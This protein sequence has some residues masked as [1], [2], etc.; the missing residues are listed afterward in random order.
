MAESHRG[1][2]AIASVPD[3][4]QDRLRETMVFGL[5]NADADK[6]TFYFERQVSWTDHDS[7]D[8]PWDWTSAPAS[9][10]TVAPTQPICAVEFFAPL[11]RS[12][13]QYSEVG[14]F[15]PSTVVITFV[16][17]DDFNEAYGSSYVTVGPRATKWYFRYWKPEVSLGNIP[18]LQAHFQAE[19]TT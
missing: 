13:A 15:F 5:P 7:E 18:V 10:T 11:G 17:E 3:F 14:D 1:V 16:S 12:G 9:D 4:V 2:D 6:P 8:K 19:D